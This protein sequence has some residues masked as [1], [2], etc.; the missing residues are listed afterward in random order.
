MKY[1]VYK[2]INKINNKFYIGVHKTNN[3][4]DSYMGSGKIIKKAIKKYGKD[5]FQKEILFIF[6]TKLEAYS[7]ERELVTEE[8]IKD[9]NCYNVNIGGCG[10]WDLANKLKQKKVL[11]RRSLEESNIWMNRNDPRIASGE[12]KPSAY[13]TNKSRD[14]GK[15][16]PDKIIGKEIHIFD[17]RGN[18]VYICKKNFGKVCDKYNLPKKSLITSY[19]NNGAKIFQS[20]R[21]L[22][23]C[24]KY[25]YEE[26]IG[27]SAKIIID[28]IV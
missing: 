14:Y 19:R 24:K 20:T 18:V 15:R 3:P 5:N 4:M 1:T 6:E 12:Y 9:K 2:I 21:Q 10:S 22:N 27:W 28:H 8:L 13:F 23:A 25:G 26:F 16:K 17:E 7:K 11:V